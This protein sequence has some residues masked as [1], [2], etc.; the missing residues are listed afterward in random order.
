[1]CEKNKTA[2]K[3]STIIPTM[4]KI[5]KTIQ[6]KILYT[7]QRIT[8]ESKYKKWARLTPNPRFWLPENKGTQSGRVKGIGR[9]R[10]EGTLNFIDNV[11]NIK[12]LKQI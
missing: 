7:V 4:K 5:L 9:E 6:T 10:I 8:H 12:K 1:M 2:K 3:Y 11:F